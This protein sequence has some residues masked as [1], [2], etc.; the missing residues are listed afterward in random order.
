VLLSAVNKVVNGE[1]ERF[2]K[3]T[4]LRAYGCAKFSTKP[5][6]FSGQTVLSEISAAC[7][8]F[9]HIFRPHYDNVRI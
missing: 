9:Y 4:F 6:N 8:A 5:Y 1:I 3:Q 2:L 7:R